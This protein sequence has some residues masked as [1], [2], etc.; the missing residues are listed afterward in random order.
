MKKI[1]KRRK[2]GVVQSYWKGNIEKLT[3]KNN[4]FRKV[5]FTGKNEQLVVMTIPVGGDIG[6]EMHKDVD[7]F[8]RVEEGKAKF[9][10][11]NKT[12][13]LGPGGASVIGK[14]TWHNVKNVGNVPLRLYTLYSPSNHP[15]GTIDKTK[16]DAI[17]R[18]KHG[19]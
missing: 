6:K 17:I 7:Q 14:G 5:I 3:E 13:T 16:M 8:F 19:N 2:D 10:M 1:L 18:E 15:D 9:V 12:F 11:K 4:N